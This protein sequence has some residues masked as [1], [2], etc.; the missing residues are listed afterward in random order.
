MHAAAV[1]QEERQILSGLQISAPLQFWAGEQVVS[2]SCWQMPMS[3]ARRQ[4]WPEG[5]SRVS[6]H[7]WWQVANRH[8]KG[9]LQSLSRLQ[10]PDTV[11]FLFPLLQAAAASK[12][13]HK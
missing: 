6:L 2:A 13:R 9:S 12:T 5:Q 10:A 1:V 11:S 7:C 3:P 8:T 4:R